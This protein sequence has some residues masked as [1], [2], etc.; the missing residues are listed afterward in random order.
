MWSSSS[1]TTDYDRRCLLPRKPYPFSLSLS[2]S[3]DGLALRFFY[4]IYFYW[5]EIG[6]WIMFRDRT[7]GI[8]QKGEKELLTN[9]GMARVSWENV[10]IFLWGCASGVLGFRHVEDKSVIIKIV[11]LPIWRRWWKSVWITSRLDIVFFYYFHF[12]RFFFQQYLTHNIFFLPVYFFFSQSII[13]YIVCRKVKRRWKTDR[14]SIN[15]V[16][17]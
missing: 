10:F 11:F 5:N 8:I 3:S 14:W 1:S 4:N 7:T 16:P 13:F 2:Q 9:D 6:K 12:V 17:C 15:Y